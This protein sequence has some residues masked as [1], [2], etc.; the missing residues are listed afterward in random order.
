MKQSNFE[1][2]TPINVP[3]KRMSRLLQSAV[4]FHHNSIENKTKKPLKLQ[5]TF[6][7]TNEAINC[8][9][10][11]LE[12]EASHSF[13]QDNAVQFN[14]RDLNNLQTYD[15]DTS[16]PSIMIE[17]MVTNN[18]KKTDKLITIFKADVRIRKDN[19]SHYFKNPS[20]LTESEQIKQDKQD[21][22][23]HDKAVKSFETFQKK[24]LERVE[25]T[26]AKKEYNDLKKEHKKETTKCNN[27]EKKIANTNSP[28]KKNELQKELDSTK[29]KLNETTDSMKTAQSAL[30]PPK[31]KKI[32]PPPSSCGGYPSDTDD[33][34]DDDMDTNHKTHEQDVMETDEI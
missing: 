23:A 26:L 6:S 7:N 27:L 21:L 15:L 2:K 30:P 24:E 32:K 25:N 29:S 20:Q 12:Y 17:H 4:R 31:E 18:T 19:D 10:T 14:S 1:T 11:V 28:E 8:F 3:V 16:T 5:T 13:S 22:K 33:D 9:R 34:T